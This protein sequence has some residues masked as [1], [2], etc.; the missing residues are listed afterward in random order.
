MR[1]IIS[2]QLLLWLAIS[3]FAK[4]PGCHSIPPLSKRISPVTDQLIQKNNSNFFLHHCLSSIIIEPLLVVDG[5]VFEYNKFQKINPDDIESI[6]ILK[7][8]Y[9]MS[10]YGEQGE[11]GVILIRTKP[12]GLM[13]PEIK[14]SLRKK[15]S[16]EKNHMNKIL[17]NALFKVFPNP[18]Q[19]GKSLNIEWK[20]PEE[21]EY[22]L[23][24]FNQAGQLTFNKEMWIDKEARVL[25]LEIPH[26]AAGNYFLRMT[27]TKSGKAFTEKI[28]IY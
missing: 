10:L 3:A 1:K 16:S 26:V 5:V 20:Q 8:V 12:F 24:L 13:Q 25:N 18:A 2:F 4:N 6:D 9:A 19:A 11:Q 23:Q 27:N 17:N 15:D 28:I 7:G 14:D 21:G 22:M